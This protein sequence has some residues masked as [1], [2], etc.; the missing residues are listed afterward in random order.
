MG[1]AREELDGSRLNPMKSDRR[2]WLRMVLLCKNHTD[3]GVMW[4][5]FHNLLKT[6]EKQE[7]ILLTMCYS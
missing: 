1:R 5:I 2:P 3:C 7:W 4:F 6:L